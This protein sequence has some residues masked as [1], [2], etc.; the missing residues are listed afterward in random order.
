MAILIMS[1]GKNGINRSSDVR[2]IQIL[3]NQQSIPGESK[4][5]VIDGKAGRQTISRI[6][7][8]QRKILKFSRPDGKVDPTGITFKS[9]NGR[10]N[11]GLFP[12][13]Q[14][15]SLSI[16]GLEYIKSLEGLGLKPYDDQT[17]EEIKSWVSGATIG[18][19]HLIAQA[20]WLQYKDGL[21][22]TKAHALLIKDLAPFVSA[23]NSAIKRPINQQ[24]FDALAILAFNIG[25]SAFTNSSVVK[26]VND[27]TA[28]V[29]YL[30]LK[31][32]W[33]AWTKSQGK[34]MRGLVNRRSAEWR[35]FENGVYP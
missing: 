15:R 18:Y 31:A 35:I 33:M 12:H 13:Q 25:S 6:Q 21:T 7:S 5:L 10:S 32:A 9:L 30:N 1:V 2:T 22:E 19:G 8:Y 4:K 26:L 14:A 3:L 20:E 34:Q 23:V 11:G 29:G 24:Q 16:K 27:P 28:V 17:G